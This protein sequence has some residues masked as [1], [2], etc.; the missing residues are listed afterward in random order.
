MSPLT[1]KEIEL[2]RADWKAVV[3]IAAIAA[4]LFYENLFMLDPH[5][6]VMFRPDMREQKQKLVAMLT[7]IVEKL[8]D[9][10]WLKPVLERLGHRHKRYGVRPEHYGPVGAALIATL[11]EGIGPSFDEAHE[12]AWG[13]AYHLLAE[14]MQ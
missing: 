4:S 8:D 10:A 2:I 14:R 1:D 12:A 6:R 9:D 3:P 5:L 7:L 13:N 11:R